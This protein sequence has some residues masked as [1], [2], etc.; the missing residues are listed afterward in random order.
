M[1][2]AREDD[3]AN[4]AHG[5][6]KQG[7][8]REAVPHDGRWYDGVLMPVLGREWAARRDQRGAGT[9]TGSS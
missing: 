8:R 7:R 2:G 4:L 5:K 3:V 6:K 1:R 9:S